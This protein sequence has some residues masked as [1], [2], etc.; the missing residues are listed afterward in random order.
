MSETLTGLSSPNDKDGSICPKCGTKN[1]VSRPIDRCPVC[2]LRA[3][4]ESEKTAA[5]T[6]SEP[7]P[8]PLPGLASHDQFEHYE[9][10]RHSDGRPIELGRGAMGVTYRAFDRNL[11]CP[12][13]L[14]V[15][16]ARYLNDESARVRF[17]REARAAA[18]LRHPNVASVFHL[19]TRNG[20]YFYAMEFVEGETIDQLIRRQGALSI[21]LAIDIVD[22]V[23][24]ALEA[25]YK[26][27]IVHRDIK[28]GNMLIRFNDDG[29][30][31]VKVIDF[32]LVKA[33]ANL[34]SE[35][36]LS[37]PGG[38]TGTALFASPE[39]CA[40]G[41][42]D[43]RSDIYSLGVTFWE[44]LTAKAAFYRI[45]SPSDEPASACSVAAGTLEG[46]TGGG[47]YF[48]EEDAGQE[49]GSTPADSGRAAFA[50]ARS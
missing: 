41:E 23:A 49:P 40:G 33:T 48:V 36:E 27:Q 43:T 8:Q 20:E 18:R 14:K 37:L 1:P 5:V 22:Q 31:N 29:A 34:Q 11:R 30:A 42:V 13:A 10:L 16:N 47:R 28:P 50:I 21:T 6:E 38:F 17:V 32:G 2:Q 45:D 12:V 4:L 24:A 44:I 26:E 25:A 46:L 19:G 7:A 15:I 35:P 3:A 39:Q 9:L